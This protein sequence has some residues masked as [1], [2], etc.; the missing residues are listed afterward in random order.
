[1]RYIVDDPADGSEDGSFIWRT[2]VA[3]VE[4]TRLAL[5]AAGVAATGGLT[6]DGTP[7]F[8]QD[9][10]A[11]TEE[12]APASGD[13]VIGCTALDE[14][15]CQKIPLSSLV[16]AG[17][18]IGISGNSL[19]WAPSELGSVT[20][21]NSGSASLTWAWALSGA[22]DPSLTIADN[23]VTSNVPWHFPSVTVGDGTAAGELPLYE[24]SANGSE[25]RSWLSPDSLTA[26][27]RFR[28]G[29]AA[30][31]ANQFMLFGAPS[32]GISSQTYRTFGH[33]AIVQVLGPA[34]AAS[35]G[36]GKRYITIP[37]E[38]NGMD[39]TYVAAHV[40]STGTTGTLNVDLARCDPVATG[41]T[42][43]G[44]VGDMLSTNLTIDSGESK[45]STAAAAAVIDAAVD[46][47]TTGDVIR[48]DIDAIHTTPSQGLI[49]E[50]GFSLP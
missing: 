2:M 34:T 20:I 45:S 37:P 38:V 35:T 16:G 1:M 43:S 46:D 44:T 24:L 39:L 11:I 22:T 47:V 10:T 5:N 29:D 21:S 3:G 26:T 6:L 15:V 7:V 36:D 18:G 9:T 13:Y 33:T 14:T 23:L 48:V 28:F 41:N 8:I 42:C 50:F 31:A 40:I 32:G 19:S 25:Y 12:T 4:T 49:L 27:V 30:P 17:S